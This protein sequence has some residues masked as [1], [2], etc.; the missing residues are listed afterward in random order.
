MK[1]PSV[2]II[3]LNWNGKDVLKDCLSSLFKTTGYK[4]F[5]AVVVDNGSVDTSVEMVRHLY[6]KVDVLENKTNLG[7]MKGNNVGIEF[8][9]ER[10][11]PDYV[12]LLNNDTKIIQHD[13][14]ERLVIVAESDRDIGLVCPKLVFPDGRIQWSGRKKESNLVYLM[15]QA[16]S[17]SL[18]PGIGLDE[19]SSSFVGEVNTVSGACMLIK[20]GLI[21]SIGSLDEGLSPFYQDDVEYSFR[22]KKFGY[23][24]VYVGDSK[25]IHL[26][27]YSFRKRGISDKNLYLALRN[28]LIV[29]KKYFGFFRTSFIGL[30]II[31][32]TCIFERS[33]KTLGFSI[34]NLK[35]RKNPFAKFWILI[36]IMKYL[37]R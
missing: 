10:Y 35:V 9:I 32:L 33:D 16:L 3:V 12:L 8:V 11:N 31:M 19:T 6:K 29:S 36:K 14:L 18:N 24:V 22:A 13:W 23:K 21:K 1:E 2:C 30:P 25:V 5:R 28:S 37:F 7:F 17:A 4:N 27:S 20:T 15:I 26:Q 34:K